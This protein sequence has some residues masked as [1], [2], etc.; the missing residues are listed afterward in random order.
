MKGFTIRA[1]RP[2]DRWE[3]AELICI[4][5]N[6]WYQ[7]HGFPM[8]F[9]AGPQ[10]TVFHFDTYHTLEGSSGIVAVDAESR[11][12]IGSCFQHVRPTHVSLGIMNVHPNHARRGVAGALLREIVEKA[13]NAGKPV[14]LVSSA[15]NLDSYS[16][17]NRAGFVTFG[18]YQDMTVRVPAEGF[19]EPLAA[20]PRVRPASLEDLDA[21]IDLE[22]E[23]AFIE[24]PGDYRHFLQNADGNW[25]V[26]VCADAAEPGRL[27]GVLVSCLHPACNMIGPGAMRTS[28]AAVALLQAELNVNAGHAPV[29]LVPV[30]ESEMVRQ[31]YAWGA[32]NCELHFAQIRDGLHPRRVNGIAMPT[33]MPES[34]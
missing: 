21:I 25:H 29:F 10:S 26:S 12:I 6:Y 3:V 18:V 32:R 11:H 27:E 9:A 4:S 2:E 24:R 23:V 28:D 14:R 13:G 33:F 5:T 31:A 17:Y 8:I 15:M 22:R 7:I 30:T 34:N 16:L 20:S 19:R 1:M